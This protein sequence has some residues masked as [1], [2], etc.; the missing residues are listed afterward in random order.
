MFKTF[1]VLFVLGLGLGVWLGFNPQAHE[2]TIK[3]WDD[4][5]TFFVSVKTDFSAVT[6]DWMAQLKSGERS[7]AEQV[8]LAWEQISSVFTPLWD[9]GRHIWLELTTRINTKR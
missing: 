3:S 2:K 4:T 1:A 8:S 6:Q 9:S 7:G 5:K